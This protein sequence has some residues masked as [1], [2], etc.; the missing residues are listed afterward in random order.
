M[1]KATKHYLL[2][3]GDEINNFDLV[4]EATSGQNAKEVWRHYYDNPGTPDRCF[5][6]PPL[7]GASRACPWKEIRL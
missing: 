5:E 4:V 3:A 6:L 2:F 7:R 1:A